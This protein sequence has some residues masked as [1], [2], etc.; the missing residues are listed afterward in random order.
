MIRWCCGICPKSGGHGY[1]TGLATE[2][3]FDEANPKRWSF[4]LRPAS[5]WPDAATQADDRGV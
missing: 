3:Q 2:W 4:K 1:Q 5:K